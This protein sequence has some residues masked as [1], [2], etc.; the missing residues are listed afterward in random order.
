MTGRIIGLKTMSEHLT[1]KTEK[2]KRT[3]V[4]GNDYIRRDNE[5]CLIV[6]NI[7]R[8]GCSKIQNSIHP[9]LNLIAIFYHDLML[10]LTNY[11]LKKN[12]VKYYS[13]VINFE[14]YPENRCQP[15]Y[16][17]YRDVIHGINDGNKIY[18][19]RKIVSYKTQFKLYLKKLL[20]GDKDS[21]KLA[22]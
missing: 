7:L 12:E 13:G 9:Y 8:K 5:E 18:K 11:V 4:G 6:Y 19:K 10:I 14:A 15:S 21:N 16:I 2:P 20:F 1:H 22:I 3:F 17:N